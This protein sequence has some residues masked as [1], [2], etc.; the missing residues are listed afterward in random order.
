MTGVLEEWVPS[1]GLALALT[2]PVAAL[3]AAA[4][5]WVGRLRVRRGLRTAYTRKIYHFVVFSL[6]GL[7]HLLWGRPAAVLLGV[8]VAAWVLRAVWKGAGHPFYEAL[9]R[10]AD[11]PRRS[12]FILVPLVTTAVGGVAANLLFPRFAHVGYLVCG[13][14][15]AVGEPVGARWGRHPYRVLSLAGVRA[16]RTLEGSAAVLLVGWLAAVAGLAAVGVPHRAA[17][18]AAVGVAGASATVEAVSNHGVD[19]LTIQVVAAGAATALA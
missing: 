2:P 9:A 7:L 12:L 16:E 13:W 11:A 10:P 6:A 15:D 1:A 19:N 18:A 8:V 14:G 4:G 17:L 3:V 5:W